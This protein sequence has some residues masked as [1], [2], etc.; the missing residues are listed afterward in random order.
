[1]HNINSSGEYLERLVAEIFRALGYEDVRNNPQGMTALERH[2]EIDVSFIRDGE[3]GVAE[4]KHYRYLS[5]PTPSLFL[6]ALRQADSVRELVGARVAIL[7]FSCPLTPSL[8]EAAKAY[9]LVEIWDAAELFRRAAGF[10]GLTRKL[11]HF[12]EATTSPYTKP[13]LA[14]EAGLSETKGMPQKTGRRLADTLLGIRPGRKMAAAFE[15]ACI[16]ALKY[17]FETDLHGWHEQSNTDDELHR[18]DLICRI[19]PN[20]EI[21]KL[22]LDDL[23]SRYVI[24]EFKNYTDPIT[25]KEVVTTE[26]YLYPSALRKLAI[27]ISP[28]GCAPSADKVIRGAM[29][30]GGKL[31]VSLTVPQIEKLLIAKDDGGDPNTYLFERVDEFLMGLGR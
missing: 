21:W 13:A 16:A 19:L 3:V 6:K 7:A 14:L 31:I 26:R 10:P 24:F 4:V 15:D 9:P 2:Y 18:R 20:A 23:G 28:K 29:R 22:M 8:A 11:E 25:Q 27:M 1:V 5:P 12:F 30:E 17:L